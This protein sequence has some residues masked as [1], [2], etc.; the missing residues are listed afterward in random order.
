MILILTIAVSFLALKNWRNNDTSSFTGFIVVLGGFAVIVD[1]RVCIYTGWCNGNILVSLSSA[2]RSNR[3]PGPKNLNKEET[4]TTESTMATLLNELGTVVT[5]A[6][7]WVVEAVDVI[8]ANP[9][10]LLTTGFLVL[11]GAIGILGRLLSRN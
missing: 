4:K 6:L 3:P 9:F 7:T 8:V 5:E 11:G 2:G 1:E 10:L